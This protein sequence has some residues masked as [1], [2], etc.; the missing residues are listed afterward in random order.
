METNA[1]GIA[2]TKSQSHKCLGRCIYIYVSQVWFAADIH[3]ILRMEN[4]IIVKAGS[5]FLDFFINV[6]EEINVKYICRLA[7]STSCL[8]NMLW[9]IY[10]TKLKCNTNYLHPR[11]R[12]HGNIFGSDADWQTRQA[13]RIKKTTLWYK[14][15]DRTRQKNGRADGQDEE[16]NRL[17][18]GWRNRTSDDLFLTVWREKQLWG[19]KLEDLT[20]KRE[21]CMKTDDWHPPPPSHSP[22]LHTIAMETAPRV[23]S[24]HTCAARRFHYRHEVKTS[25]W[26]RQPRM[27]CVLAAMS[28]R[29]QHLTLQHRLGLVC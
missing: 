5:I 14:K 3:C 9:N 29:P 10:S 27:Q 1:A 20:R 22:S 21:R 6:N 4:K 28:S 11:T 18:G 12:W 24:L 25:T 26:H 19:K 23:L 7:C 15:M 17:T 13:G 16:T 8:D 2:G